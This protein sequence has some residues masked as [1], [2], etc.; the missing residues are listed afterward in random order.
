MSAPPGGRWLICALLLGLGCG[1]DRPAVT[2]PELLGMDADQVVVNLEHRM[3]REG[4]VRGH[5]VADSAYIYRSE[6]RIRLRTLR[7]GFFGDGGSEMSVLTAEHG[8]YDLG[9]GDMLVH[10]DVT[11]TDEALDRRLTTER[12]RFD[13]AADQLVGDTAFVM[14]QGSSTT[15]GESFTSD[16]QMSV[17]DMEGPTLTKPGVAP[18]D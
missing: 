6:A 17:V 16:P 2:P 9:S 5:L 4:V 7:I 14:T 13:A 12:L 18:I 15:R 3:T 11:V 10:G 8:T 1:E